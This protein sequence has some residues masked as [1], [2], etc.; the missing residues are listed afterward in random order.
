M[1]LSYEAE[2]LINSKWMLL[3]SCMCDSCEQNSSFSVSRIVAKFHMA[4]WFEY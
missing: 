4:V 3:A 2:L 1:A